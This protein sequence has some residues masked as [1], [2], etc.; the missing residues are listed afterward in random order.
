[1]PRAPPT[2][3]LLPYTPL[4]RSADHVDADGVLELEHQAGADR[5]DDRGG[6]ALLAVRRICEVQ[7]LLRVDV[8][9]GPATHDVGHRVRQHPPRSEEHTSELQSRENLVCRL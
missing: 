8:R 3:P 1:P 5:L 6:A 7:V 2:R 4:F 9:D